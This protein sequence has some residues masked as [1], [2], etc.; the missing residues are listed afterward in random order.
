M[1]GGRAARPSERPGGGRHWRAAGDG[2]GPPQG[3]PAWVGGGPLSMPYM[4]V[5][6]LCLTFNQDFFVK[7]NF[8]IFHVVKFGFLKI[9]GF[10]CLLLYNALLYPMVFLYF[11][12]YSFVFSI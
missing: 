8:S 1:A 3:R 7:Q 2:E 6:F 9:C 10:I 4:H 12:F 11:L 5:L